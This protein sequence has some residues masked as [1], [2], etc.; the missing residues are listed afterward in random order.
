MDGF[1]LPDTESPLV[2]GRLHV[3]WLPPTSLEKGEKGRGSSLRG[4][5]LGPQLQ[6]GALTPSA[7]L[8]DAPG[9]PGLLPGL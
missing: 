5:A 2:L 6:R 1:V 4:G 7:S 9:P 8:G 3:C